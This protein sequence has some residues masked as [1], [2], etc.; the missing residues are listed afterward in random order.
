MPL[1]LFSR[2]TY[3]VPDRLLVGA[4]PGCRLIVPF[5]KTKKYTALSIRLHDEKPSEYE[6]KE[7]LEAPD[8]KPVLLPLQIELL[9]W[10]SEYYLCA[11][12]DVLNSFLPSRMRLNIKSNSLKS[13]FVNT[14][15]LNQSLS[16]QDLYLF[17]ES[18]R[19]APRRIDILR[20]FIKMAKYEGVDVTTFEVPRKE[21]LAKSSFAPALKWLIDNGVLSL[22]QR[23]V[24]RQK[25][26]IFDT[27]QP[28]TLNLEQSKAMV[29]IKSA[30]N[31][32]K[33]CLLHGVT[34]SGKTEIYIH[35]I[36]ESI[37]LGF[38]VLYLLPE[39]ALTSQITNRLQ[40]IFG[41]SMCVYHSGRTES[42]RVKIRNKQLSESPYSLVL[43]A[44]SAIFLPF[45]NL[46][47]IVVDEEHE[48]SYK[49]ED[50]APRYNARN[51]AVVL[52]K[53]SNANIV[54]GSATPS[55]ESYYNAV[56]G[57]YSLVSMKKRYM[58]LLM[59]EIILVDIKEHI[60]KKKMKGIFSPLLI[61]KIKLALLEKEQVILFQNR[62]GYSP[63]LECTSC[64][65]V[66]RCESCD[67]AL[68]YHKILD[69][70][71]CHYCGKRYIVTNIC[72]SCDNDRF[73]GR[74]FGTERAEEEI[75]KIFP[76]AR[77]SRLDYDTAGKRKQIETILNNFQKG[78]T[79]IL[80]GT[81]MVSK[82]LDF[83]NVR[84]VGILNA[85]SIL[86]YPDFR[87]VE[88]AY[89]M[90]AQVSGRAG[91]KRERGVVILQTRQID[92][93]VIGQVVRNDY[94]GMFRNQIEERKQFLYPPFCRLIA[95]YVKGRAERD[96]S[97]AAELLSR[98]LRILFQDR[99]LGPDAPS[100]ARIQSYFYMKILIKIDPSIS[101]KAA[102]IRL[103]EIKTSLDKS[104]VFRKVSIYFDADPI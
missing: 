63:V 66:P 58:N 73:E 68:T 14:I 3:S 83:D 74:G 95:V 39:I 34:S 16:L 62:R 8:T 51:V 46:G 94:D 61:E 7:V 60:R 79:D 67:V 81:Q 6:I 21:L 1:P 71:T 97:Q 96:V 25:E 5:G 93:D 43:G 102:R 69:R 40:K 56:T 36:K 104:A 35:L 76:Q 55:V 29:E 64:G 54:L 42:E 17:I 41:N 72:P 65:W 28:N 100:I 44:R 33:V 80:I 4:E 38:Q 27:K 18:S 85:D 90:M 31:L 99:V 19:N 48:S 47:L 15:K 52:A 10:I 23:P 75:L 92:N 87:S 84:V 45:K 57:K 11:E 70:V 2:F 12:G 88:R 86:N 50:P 9:L 30:F 103:I 91:R 53:K 59:P 32:N 77:V 82:G 20:T 22:I 49:Q 26:E 37:E 98:E 13:D 24:N 78:D 101:D 89:Q